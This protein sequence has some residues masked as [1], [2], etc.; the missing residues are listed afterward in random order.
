VQ[1]TI[2]DLAPSLEA[3]L[4]PP[5]AMTV[6]GLDFAVE[7]AG[8]LL[9]TSP[10]SEAVAPTEAFASLSADLVEQLTR[11]SIPAGTTLIEQGSAEVAMYLVVSGDLVVTRRQQDGSLHRLRRVGS[12]AIVGEN[13]LLMGTPRTASIIAES[14]SD[15]FEVSQSDYERLR[16]LAP[17]LALE[18]QDHVLTE[19]A[20]R[21]VSLSEHLAR[22]LR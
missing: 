3:N 5:A 21:S 19:L 15:V 16:R 8:N 17:K 11:R 2:T 7:L 10:T 12:G 6:E 18:L 20:T 9:L 1:L 14:P 22:A 13:A 4:H